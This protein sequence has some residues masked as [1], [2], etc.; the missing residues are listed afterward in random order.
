[1]PRPLI[2]NDFQLHALA[3][4]Q[5]SNIT[6]VSPLAKTS[7]FGSRYQLDR[8]GGRSRGVWT[9]DLTARRSCKRT[10]RRTGCLEF[11]RD[12]NT[13]SSWS[14]SVACMS[15]AWP[16]LLRSYKS[17]SRMHKNQN[18]EFIQKHNPAI[19]A[20]NPNG[21]HPPVS[22]SSNRL[23]ANIMRRVC[24][25]DYGGCVRPG[26]P[27]IGSELSAMYHA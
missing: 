25:F 10:K 18:H 17:R 20:S 5:P 3:T 6:V 24:N 16:R 8:V 1:M 4:F 26:H 9:C 13:Y 12:H 19:W 15:C 23:A 7:C 11:C 14:L 27:F 22:S 21:H 2:S